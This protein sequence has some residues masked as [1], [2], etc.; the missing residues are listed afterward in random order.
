MAGHSKWANIKHRKAA[1]D[2]KR[3]KVFQ[4]LSKEIYISAKQNGANPD[5]NSNLRLLLLK[6]KA[7]NMPKSIIDKALNK[8]KSKDQSNWEEIIYEGYGSGGSAFIVKCLSDNRNRVASFV[9]STFRKFGGNL[10][11]DGA[12]KYLFTLTG[13][14]NITTDLKEDNLVDKLLDL[15]IENYEHL[16]GLEYIIFATPKNLN[17]ISTFLSEDVDINVDD[18]GLEFIPN[19]II[20]LA[21]D[22]IAMCQKLRDT[23]MDSEDISEVF[24]NVAIND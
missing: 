6:A 5:I 15:D 14:I 19:E 13:Y 11:S 3:G 16:D 2:N 21:S 18:F 9:K 20:E 12:V 7:S 22:K 8:S 4:K 1:Q 23:L 17:N 10:G 24:C